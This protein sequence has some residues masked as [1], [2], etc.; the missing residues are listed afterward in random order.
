MALMRTD[1]L[2]P[3]TLPV[4]WVTAM[5]NWMN[6]F[7]RYPALPFS[8]L[9]VQGHADRTVDWKHGLGVLRRLSDPEILEIPAARHHLVNE[10]EAVRRQIFD[11]LGPRLKE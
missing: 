5:V 10:S 3:T 2:A 8:P 6:R 4:Q 11:W 1:P 7:E 9:V